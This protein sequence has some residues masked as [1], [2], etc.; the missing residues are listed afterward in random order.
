MGVAY[1]RC[2]IKHE[3]LSLV[4]CYGLPA[5]GLQNGGYTAVTTN[6]LVYEQG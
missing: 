4:F 6:V 1:S 5:E 2:F 3:D